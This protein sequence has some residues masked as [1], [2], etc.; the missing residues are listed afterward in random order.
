MKIGLRRSD[1]PDEGVSRAL[2]AS[3]GFAFAGAMFAFFAS[4]ILD[5]TYW[6]GGGVLAGCFLGTA[7]AWVA[8]LLNRS[9]NYMD[10]ILTSVFAIFATLLSIR[11]MAEIFRWV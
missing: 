11:T 5:Q 10:R 2:S 3:T 7:V 6:G 8:L 1:Y 9:K 4:V